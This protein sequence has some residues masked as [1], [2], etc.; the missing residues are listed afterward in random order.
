MEQPFEIIRDN[1]PLLDIIVNTSSKYLPLCS[2]YMENTREIN[3]TRS[4]ARVIRPIKGYVS[5]CITSRI[6]ICPE[7]LR[8]GSAHDQFGE[9]WKDKSVD[10]DESEATR[11]V[12]AVTAPPP[13]AF[14]LAVVGA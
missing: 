2:K 10:R 8:F 1:K 4:I 11:N 6:D 12:G 9:E 7:I 5:S 13:V 3:G 14:R